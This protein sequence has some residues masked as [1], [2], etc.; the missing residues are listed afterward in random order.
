MPS[1]VCYTRISWIRPFKFVLWFVTNYSQEVLLLDK[2]NI[3]VNHSKK[4]F[5]AI[6]DVHPVQYCWV[7]INE[8]WKESNHI[9]GVI[10]PLFVLTISTTFVVMCRIITFWGVYTVTFINSIPVT[11]CW[12][13]GNLSRLV[14]KPTKWH[15]RPAK[16]QI[17]L[18]IRPVWSE[19][20]QSAWRKLGSSAIHWAQ[21]EDS[22]QTGR[23]PRLVWVFAGRTVILLVLSRGGSIFNVWAVWRFS[24]SIKIFQ[25]C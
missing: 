17:S 5:T 23:M 18:G 25:S 6:M 14:T 20:S 7:F 11:T 9:T 10:M 13:I 3:P 21:S 1:I 4:T 8:N 22:D 16:T 19:P 2:T 24:F 12:K 15:V